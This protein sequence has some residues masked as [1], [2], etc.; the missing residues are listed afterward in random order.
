MTVYSLLIDGD[1]IYAGTYPNGDVFKST[2]GG[3]S[4][5]NTADIP[6]ATSVRAMVRLQDGDILVATSPHGL[7]HRN[8]IFRTPDGGLSWTEITALRHINP[9]KFLYETSTGSLFAG[10]WAYDSMIRIHRSHSNGASWDSL[11]VISQ[12]EP[13]WTADAF[14]EA[15]DGTLYVSGWIPGHGAGSGGGFVYRSGD[16]GTSWTACE[17]IVRDDGYHNCRTYAI[18]QDPLGTIYVGIQPTPDQVVYASSNNGRSW[19]ST[20]GLDGAY[21]CLCL[22]MASDGRLYAGTTPNG[23]VFAYD[24][25]VGVEEGEPLA[26]GM[27]ALYRNH[28]N[29]FRL[30]TTIEFVVPEGASGTT[31][32]QVF[33]VSGRL[34]RRLAE[35]T[36]GPGR[37]AIEWDGRDDAGTALPSGIYFC[38]MEVRGETRTRKLV[39]AR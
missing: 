4:W 31:A 2:D 24:A 11:E 10:G 15:S 26:D 21:E 38:R 22:L 9:C 12:F 8:S 34:V 33:D 6:G 13:D 23:D 27:P 29:P 3:D 39:L 17:K 36:H 5:V 7:T 37:H 1:E 14:Y 30:T 16:D 19:S 18:A 32:L 35:G 25:P 20:G 28:P